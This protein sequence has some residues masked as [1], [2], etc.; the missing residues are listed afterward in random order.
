M[1]LMLAMNMN[2]NFQISCANESLLLSQ[3]ALY[4]PIRQYGM[5]K[6]IQGRKVICKGTYHTNLVWQKSLKQGVDVIA[7]FHCLFI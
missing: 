6:H 1:Q 5:E 7:C 3:N 4:I 2:H